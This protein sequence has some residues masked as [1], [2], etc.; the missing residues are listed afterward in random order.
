M[1]IKIAV[2]VFNTVRYRFICFNIEDPFCNQICMQPQ[3]KLVQLASAN[4]VAQFLSRDGI[5]LGRT[6][7]KYIQYPLEIGNS[8][9]C[10]IIG[11]MNVVSTINSLQRIPTYSLLA[12]CVGVSSRGLT[13]NTVYKPAIGPNS[14]IYILTNNRV[15]RAVNNNLNMIITMIVTRGGGG[16]C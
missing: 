7:M 8:M 9:L 5:L 12:K 15:L 14:V 1:A 6:E 4:R 10:F 11:L 3:W 2:W 16:G 13:T